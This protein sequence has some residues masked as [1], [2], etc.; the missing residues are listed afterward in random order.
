MFA[1]YGGP[2]RMARRTSETLEFGTRVQKSCGP[3]RMSLGAEN[4][5]SMQF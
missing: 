3:L 2:A 1:V 5:E 4:V